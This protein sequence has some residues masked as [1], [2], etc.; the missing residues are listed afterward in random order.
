MASLFG[1]VV[2]DNMLEKMPKYEGK[3]ITK[4]DRAQ[5]ARNLIDADNKNN[6]AISYLRTLKDK[7]R[8]VAST[9]CVVYNSTGNS[10]ILVTSYD[11]HGHIG[12]AP[13]PMEIGNGQWAAFIHTHDDNE[14]TGSVAGVVYR[15]INKDGLNKDCLVAWSTPWSLIQSNSAYCEVGNVSYFNRVWDDTERILEESSYYSNTASD[16]CQIDARIER[17]TSPMFTAKISA[18]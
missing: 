14:A 17:G 4:E 16:G 13:Y 8:N 10:L 1:D 9:L 5:E 11:W 18:L 6:M 12:D 7:Y 15:A 3:T 2:D